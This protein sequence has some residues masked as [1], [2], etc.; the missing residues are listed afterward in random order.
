MAREANFAFSGDFDD[1]PEIE[2]PETMQ[3]DCCG[4]MKPVDEISF[5]GAY[6]QGNS[7][8]C[9]T[10]QCD[11]CADKSYR[12][13]TGAPTEAE[14]ERSQA[15]I[16]AVLG[17]EEAEAAPWPRCNICGKSIKTPDEKPVDF[18]AGPCHE[19][20]VIDYREDIEAEKPYGRR[21]RRDPDS[22][23]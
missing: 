22:K 8:G 19:G 17:P 23:D 2:E 5:H 10:W 14:I 18:Q 7:A 4:E 20:C 16:A 13:M 12:A 15:R 9:D 21:G 11:E 6:D 1:G 3:C